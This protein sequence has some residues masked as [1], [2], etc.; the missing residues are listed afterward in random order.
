MPPEKA[1][2]ATLERI[3]VFPSSFKLTS[4][5]SEMHLVVTGH[6]AGGITR[7][8]THSAKF[9]SSDDAIVHID[10]AAVAPVSDGTATITVSVDGKRCTAKAIV[11]DAKR[12]EPVPFKYGALVALTKQGCN[13]GAC[14]GSPSG[15][16]GFRLSLRAYDP[17]FDTSTV[18]REGMNRRVNILEPEQSLLLRKPLMQVSHAGGKRLNTKDASY[19]IL[20]DWIAEG[21]NDDPADAAQC[22]RI[23]V[24]P[25]Q[26]V[27]VEPARE[28]QYLVLAH[29]S[30]GSVRDVTEVAQFSSSD[31][32][33]G[34]VDE[35]GLVTCSNRG[36][37]AVL[38]RYLEI[39]Q[40]AQLTYLKPVDSFQWSPPPENNF[41][42]K[43]VLAKLQRLEILPSDLCS[44]EEFVRRVYLDVLGK[45]PTVD[46]A[47]AFFDGK[48]DGDKHDDRRARLIDDLLARP[49]YA[50]YWGQRWADLL[51]VRKAKMSSAGVS[52]FHQWLVRAVGDNMPYDEFA[53]ALLTADGSSYAN[54]PANY[55]RAAADVNDCT[56]TT[57]QLFLG[58]RIQCAKCHN[59]PFERWTQDNYYGIA[60]FFNRVERKKTTNK[61][62]M[63]VWVSRSGEVTQPR[64]GKQMRPWLPAA[65]EVDLPGDADRREALVDWLLTRDNS[66]FARMQVNRLWGYVMGRGIV[67]PVDDFRDSNPP[68][69]PELLDA[70]AKDFVEHGY[71]CKHT[72]RVILNSRTYQ[73]SSRTNEF[74]KDDAKYFSHAKARLIPAEPLLDAICQVTGVC[75][76][77]A[78]MPEGTQA[79]QMP[80][81]DIDMDFLKTFGQPA[82]E[83]ACQ[84]ERSSDSNLS[85][86]LEVIN[87]PLLHDKLRDAKNRFR[88]M[89]AAGDTDEAIVERLYLAALSRKPTPKELAAALEHVRSSDDR[90]RGF[91]DVC[92]ALLNANEFLFQH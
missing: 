73:L 53:K 12:V 68:S 41:V 86:A 52:K 66:F 3:E 18:I 51:R 54:P 74:N 50:E 7:D 77:F 16:G 19:A 76:A 22:V 79:T 38:V 72:L 4:S 8:L 81:P 26:R 85:Q 27:L 43:H 11:S 14:H 42:D 30:D 91:E 75:Q 57:S 63:I 80:S 28:Q 24:F 33:V 69:N 47:Q 23:E 39:M 9:T 64:T 83:S 20:R 92:W 21:C 82:R 44:D 56:E 31:D 34:M 70:L 35:H 59:H 87:G 25:K 60:A 78:G 55:Y 71:D 90:A 5:R 29:F 6:Y 13:Q 49:A 36:E 10:G 48:Y 67:D 40:T 45:L 62:E 61:D 2:L 1:K 65:G 46:E 17:P 89:L 84:C 88:S 37:T 32:N 15:K 58:V